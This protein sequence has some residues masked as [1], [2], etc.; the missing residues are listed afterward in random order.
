MK[1]H[2]DTDAAYLVLSKELIITVGFYHITNTP[3]TSETFFRNGAILV[4][5]KTL[6]HVVASAAEAEIGIVLH[7]SR[8]AIPIRNKLEALGH[9]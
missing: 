7:T 8:M 4:E 6:R 5:C 1:L 2:I 3:H 9:T